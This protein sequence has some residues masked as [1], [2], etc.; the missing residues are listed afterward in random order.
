MK[1]ESKSNYS[2]ITYEELGCYV[3]NKAV[4]S[5]SAEWLNSIKSTI[6]VHKECT[7]CNKHLPLEHF[8]NDKRRLL[9][10]RSQCKTCYKDGSIKKTSTIKPKAKVKVEE[11]SAPK[12]EYT[13]TYL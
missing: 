1:Q 9:G 11:E 7:K 4:I 8:N 2:E 5:V 12:I 3:G 6:D 10:K 13:L